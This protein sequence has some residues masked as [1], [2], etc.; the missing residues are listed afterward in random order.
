MGNPKR[1]G[2]L[3]VSTSNAEIAEYPKRSRYLI[4]E[5]VNLDPN[6]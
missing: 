6:G 5:T 3:V 1:V 2:N 4:H